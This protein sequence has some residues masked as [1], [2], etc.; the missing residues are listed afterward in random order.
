MLAQTLSM[1]R[2]V[3]HG[4][5]LKFLALLSRAA[6]LF[7]VTPRLLSG[8]LSRYVFLATIA[9]LAGRVMSVG[10]EEQL[11]LRVAGDMK[12]AREFAPLIVI[13]AVI[14]VALAMLFWFTGDDVIVAVLLAVCYVTTSLFAGLVRSV[15]LEASERLR[16]LHW[17]VFA[18]LCILPAVWSAED[19]LALMAV[20]L[21]AIHIL[22][23]RI[24]GIDFSVEG[25]NWRALVAVSV[26]QLGRA[27]KKLLSSASLLL[28]V[29][30]IILWPNALRLSDNL[31][32][33][34]YAL[35]IGEAFWQTSMVLVYRRYARYCVSQESVLAKKRDARAA[36]LVLVLYALTIAAAI[37]LLGWFDVEIGRFSDWNA[38]SVF[39]IFF[40]LISSYLLIRYL[41]W[42][43]VDFDWR[44]PGFEFLFI[45]SQGLIVFLLP[46]ET[47]VFAIAAS[48]LI[49]VSL[50]FAYVWFVVDRAGDRGVNDVA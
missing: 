4:L 7:I 38:V 2:D 11:P 32:D 36:V 33:I 8:E 23:L 20:S 15:N 47:W 6:F 14:E 48:A 50:S 42:A 5:A 24:S 35:L 31:D 41:T 40:G 10:M 27:W 19:L 9:V 45:A 1:V 39:V 25:V 21:M 43:L 46:S 17:A 30:A 29:R 18:A 16:D 28:M 3:R 49:F 22:E 12:N 13:T 26:E 37:Q 34:A 44:L